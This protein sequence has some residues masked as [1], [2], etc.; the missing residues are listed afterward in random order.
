MKILK[1]LTHDYLQ[2]SEL[3][4]QQVLSDEFIFQKVA[5]LDEKYKD[6]KSHYESFEGLLSNIGSDQKSIKV[7]SC[8]IKRLKSKKN[9][10]PLDKYYY[11]LANTISAKADIEFK[12]PSDLPYLINSTR[13]KEAKNTFLLVEKDD[14]SHFERATT[15]IANILEKYGRNYEALYTYDRALRFNPNFG[16]ALG[17]KAIALEYYCLLAPQQSLVLLNQSYLLLKQALKD[18]KISEVGGPFA[19]ENFEKKLISIERYFKGEK[20][21][22]K[23]LQQP[24]NIT[25]Y[26]QFVLKNNL[27]LNYDFGYFYDRESLKDNFFPNLHEEFNSKKSSKTS[28]MSERT[29]FC[30][31]VF[32]Q[33]MEDFITSRYNFYKA[34]N[35]KCK[36]IDKDTNY[37]Y[38]YDYTAHSLKFG[39]LKSVFS[40]LYNCL[41][42]IAHLINYYFSK[43]E[44]NV[45]NLDIYFDWFTSE[46]FKEI[47]VEKQN[48][49]LLALFS[50]SLDFKSNAPFYK[51][52]RMRNR[53][54]HSFL[55]VATDYS[56]SKE[57][58]IYETSEDL[59][60]EYI[61]LL[62]ILVKSAII[63]A[64]IAIRL[65]DT[66]NNTVPMIATLQSDIFK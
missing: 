35:L 21:T 52:C 3:S 62:F 38:T 40:S 14:S 6:V 66:D 57:H 55:N 47:I 22:P 43:K 23:D 42:K 31:N 18:K 4:H 60:I 32:N 10:L 51:L 2:L 1:E 56:P 8:V 49:R 34:I 16:M 19:A 9:E 17:N 27:F 33:L 36:K 30:F 44:I 5:E 64:I 29:Y 58:E 37:V 26:Q 45:N 65:D 13:Y 53:I 20:Y 50:L 54:T 7:L 48:Y 25:K 61:H 41:D 11:D 63:Y 59:L 28:I 46:E 24:K 12:A 39:M 15:N